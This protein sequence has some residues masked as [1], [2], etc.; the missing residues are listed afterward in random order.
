MAVLAHIPRPL[1]GSWFM[2]LALDLHTLSSVFIGYDEYGHEQY[3]T[4]RSAVGEALYRWKYSQDVSTADSL[5]ETSVAALRAQNAQIDIVVPVP[6]TRSRQ[7]QPVTE[8]GVASR[9]DS[10][11]PS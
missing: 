8:V 5:A 10:A 2:G 11:F 9:S 7:V 3:D 4:T 6:S 1:Y